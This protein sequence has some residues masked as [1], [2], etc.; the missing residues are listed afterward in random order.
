MSNP[1]WVAHLTARRSTPPPPGFDPRPPYDDENEDDDHNIDTQTWDAL[2]GKEKAADKSAPVAAETQTGSAPKG[3][4]LHCELSSEPG[5]VVAVRSAPG[6][7]RSRAAAIVRRSAGLLRLPPVDVPR[8]R[9]P[10]SRAIP[11]PLDQYG[12]NL[13]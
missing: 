3:K 9:R 7:V 2:G 1:S 6:P 11:L 13:V 4:Q 8:M 10:S 5:S 12:S